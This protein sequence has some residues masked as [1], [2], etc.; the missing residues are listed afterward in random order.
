[1]SFIRVYCT[2]FHPN[3]TK[4]SAWDFRFSRRWISRCRLVNGISVSEELAVSIFRVYSKDWISRIHRND[5]TFRYYL[6]EDKTVSFET[7]HSSLFVNHSTI[8][9]YA[10]RF[11]ALYY[12]VKIL[13]LR[14][15]WLRNYI[16]RV[17]FSMIR[18]KLAGE[19][20]DAI[21]ERGF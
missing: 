8:R 10:K 14:L 15:F 12:N 21:Y 11:K 19:K 9:H 16:H 18:Y 5:S 20:V 3:L 2:L 6:D 17:K 1:M 4:Y 7:L 13:L